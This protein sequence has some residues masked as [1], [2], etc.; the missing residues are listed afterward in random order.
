M[1]TTFL[2]NTGRSNLFLYLALFLLSYCWMYYTSPILSGTCN[3]NTLSYDINIYHVIGRSWMEG[4]I[5]YRDLE[6]VKGPLQFLVYGIASLISPFNVSGILYFASAATAFSMFFVFKIAR[7]YLPLSFCV[8]AT[9]FC[10][11]GTVDFVGHPA[12]FILALQLWALYLFLRSIHEG[13]TLRTS[14]VYGLCTGLTI[15][16]KFS[17]TAFFGPLIVYQL[18]YVP[19]TPTS[20]G[21]HILLLAA[22]CLTIWLPICAYFHHTGALHALWD[23]Y[24]LTGISYAQ[25]A[26]GTPILFHPHLPFL[27]H[28]APGYPVLSEYLHRAVVAGIAM[29]F[30]LGGLFCTTLQ[31][32]RYGL[33]RSAC[34]CLW[35]VLIISLLAT[36][37]TPYYFLHYFFPFYPFVFLTII[38]AINYIRKYDWL[39]RHGHLLALCS[40]VPV[41]LLAGLLHHRNEDYLSR[42]KEQQ[43]SLE[44]IKSIIHPQDRP[45]PAIL[46]VA[47]SLTGFYRFSPYPPPSKH[48]IPQLTE[49]G[50][51]AWKNECLGIIA[52]EQADII[53]CLIDQEGLPQ[54]VPQEISTAI[55]GYY[56]LER[57]LPFTFP[58]VDNTVGI[59]LRKNRTEQPAP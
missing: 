12:E 2:P 22:G 23:G 51:Q 6:D 50:K 55:R 31:K 32:E 8:V 59:F 4:V 27:G 40:I 48:F 3:Q 53:F 38:V 1:N 47:P 36:M 11:A 33:T 45:S 43:A 44:T 49:K 10:L 13:S 7:L 18:L 17:L 30:L 39:R 15:A 57:T 42:C 21:K 58:E 46:T 5:P 9:A 54:K 35:S 29:I 41:A 20:W 26:Q 16:F 28:F 14:F 56:R 24:F 25:E 37:S 19:R 34:L 52:S